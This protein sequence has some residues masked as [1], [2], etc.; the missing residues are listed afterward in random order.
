[1]RNDDT[2]EEKSEEICK[3]IHINMTNNDKINENEFVNGAVSNEIY[4]D[5]IC[6]N[7]I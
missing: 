4:I 1:M 2:H 3:S 7:D 6:P 5:I